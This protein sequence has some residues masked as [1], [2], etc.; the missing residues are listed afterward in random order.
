MAD[1]RVES[2]TLLRITVPRERDQLTEVLGILHELEIPVGSLR[3]SADDEGGAVAVRIPKDRVVEA[4]LALA[5]HGFADV[6]AYD[7]DDE[8]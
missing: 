4:V 3:S 1:E 6:R 8:P 2:G 5:Y 7:A